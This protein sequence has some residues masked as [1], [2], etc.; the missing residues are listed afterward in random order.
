MD[1]A[2]SERRLRY[3]FQK[4]PARAM[5]QHCTKFGTGLST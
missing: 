3:N 5:G 2:S 4:S 1:F